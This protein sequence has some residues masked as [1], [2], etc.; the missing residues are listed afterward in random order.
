M[1]SMQV[2]RC[3]GAGACRLARDADFWETERAV[4]FGFGQKARYFLSYN[5]YALLIVLVALGASAAAVRWGAWYVWVPVCLASLRALVW[6]WRIARQFPR[7]LHITKKL[8]RA[9]REARFSPEDVVKYCA[10]PCY[11]VVAREALAAAG[12]PR[13]QRAGMVRDYTRRAREL[14][15]DF[16]IVDRERNRVLTFVDG[17]LTE[18]P[19]NPEGVQS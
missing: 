6:A 13:A 11:R 12:V 5:R 7:K 19:L 17:V 2:E 1:E 9:Q 8:L 15:H 4:R 14:A 16:V 3:D 18:K 10:D